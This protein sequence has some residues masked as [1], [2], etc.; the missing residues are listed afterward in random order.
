MSDVD[1][2]ESNEELLK[3]LYELKSELFRE[4]A[5]AVTKGGSKNTKAIRVIR[6]NIAKA[7][8]LLESRE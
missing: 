8:T 5:T 4:R 2:K 6:K 7:L 3:K 1:P